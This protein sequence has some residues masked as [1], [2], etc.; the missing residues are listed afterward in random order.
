[1]LTQTKSRA[2]PVAP[3]SGVSPSKGGKRKKAVE[4]LTT[5]RQL[6]SPLPADVQGDDGATRDALSKDQHMSVDPIIAEI[7]GFHRTRQDLHRAEKSLTLQIK[8]IERRYNGSKNVTI[9]NDLPAT[10]TLSDGCLLSGDSENEDDEEVQLSVATQVADD[11]FIIFA[12]TKP[13]VDARKVL[14]TER[15]AAERQC[16]KAA[17]KLPVWPFVEAINGFGP[18]GLAQIIG[19]TGDLS[20]YSNPAKVWKRMGLAV[21]D[22]RAQRRVAGADALKHGYNPVRRAIM[23][24]IGDSLLKKQNSYRELYLERKKYEEQ[25]V[26]DGTKML[27]H[28]RAQRYVEKRLLRD[29]WRAWRDL[30][31]YDSHPALVSS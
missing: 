23:F 26:P 18:L 12:V 8:A 25:K 29:L 28:R 17:K 31:T 21:I 14:K 11:N 1:M 5:S 15:L 24:C 19:E 2:K 4:A 30:S 27:W 10:D 6:S 9:E 22:G 20:L 7:R 3:L 16:Q 13:F